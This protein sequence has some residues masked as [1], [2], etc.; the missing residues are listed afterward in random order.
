M[1]QNG[2]FVEDKKERRISVLE[3]SGLEPHE[4]SFRVLHSALTFPAKTQHSIVLLVDFWSATQVDLSLARL[5]S[6][7]GKKL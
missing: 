2:R 1:S 4:L 7:T 5:G 3:K 6:L